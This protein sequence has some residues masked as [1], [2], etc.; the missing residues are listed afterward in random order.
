M[1]RL[2]PIFPRQHPDLFDSPDN[3]VETRNVS[4]HVLPES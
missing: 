2:L 3:M 4:T 1:T